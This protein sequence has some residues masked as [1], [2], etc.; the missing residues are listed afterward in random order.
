MKNYLNYREM[1][2][3]ALRG[4]VR[5]ALVQVAEHGLRGNHH[6]YVSL[7][8]NHPDV[9]LSDF[10]RAK[11]ADDMT[12]VLQHQY[13]DLKVGDTAFEVSLSFNNVPEALTIPYAAMTGFADPSVQFGLQFQP[14]AESA[15]A[16]DAQTGVAAAAAELAE[17]GTQQDDEAAAPKQ[18]EAPP[19]EADAGKEAAPDKVVAL[20]TFRKK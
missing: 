3:G 8:T 11:Y 2:E 12:I 16:G 17:R 20:D 18:I 4:V 1:V 7:D 10:L 19:E 15:N 6:L 5:Q 14:E 9:V 13:W